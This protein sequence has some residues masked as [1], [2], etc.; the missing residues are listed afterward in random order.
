M[1][2][3]ISNAAFYYKEHLTLILK[4][5][6]YWLIFASYIFFCPV[7]VCAPCFMYVFFQ[8]LAEELIS[9]IF[10]VIVPILGCIYII[11]YVLFSPSFL[12]YFHVDSIVFL[13]LFGSSSF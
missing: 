9:I 10:V 11:R 4:P 12:Y 8:L 13:F 2:V 1:T 3:F 5:A 7:T 6:F